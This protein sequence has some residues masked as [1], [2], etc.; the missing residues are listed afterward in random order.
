M[1]KLP[2]PVGKNLLVN[3][4]HVFNSKVSRAM[5][6][7]YEDRFIEPLLPLIV[8]YFYEVVHGPNYIHTQ[9]GERLRD[10]LLCLGSL[11]AFSA[12]VKPAVDKL[13]IDYIYAKK[14]F[15][16]NMMILKI[17]TPVEAFNYDGSVVRDNMMYSPSDVG[18]VVRFFTNSMIVA[19]V[20]TSNEVRDPKRCTST[21]FFATVYS[22]SLLKTKHPHNIRKTLLYTVSGCFSISFLR[23]SSSDF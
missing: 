11:K 17:E 9:K 6:Y 4:F 21:P 19:N 1:T 22:S 7:S 16:S 18:C 3:K 14:K 20:T 10:S 12:S 2:R 13:V 5:S 8:H 23:C 15:P